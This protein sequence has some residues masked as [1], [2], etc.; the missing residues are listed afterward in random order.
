M[1]LT[2]KTVRLWKNGS[3][4]IPEGFLQRYSGDEQFILWKRSKD[5]NKY[6]SLIAK[7]VK[8]S[9]MEKII[10]QEN[11]VAF[12]RSFYANSDKASIKKGRLYLPKDFIDYIGSSPGS[13]VFVMDYVKAINIFDTDRFNFY[14][15]FGQALNHS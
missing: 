4:K 9:I 14:Q 6:I 2:T 15:N 8:D 11:P 12:S 1:Q 5:P 10:E 7:S 13:D 3:V